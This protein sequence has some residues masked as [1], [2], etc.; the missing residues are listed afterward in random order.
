MF[1]CANS[2]MISGYRDTPVCV[3]DG[4]ARHFQSNNIIA[5]I[6]VKVN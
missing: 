4:I 5:V 6:L 1:H 2:Y 3:V